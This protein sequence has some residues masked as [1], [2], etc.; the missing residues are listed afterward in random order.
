VGEGAGAGWQAARQA[1]IKKAV[2]RRR[3]W[4]F[5]RFAPWISAPHRWIGAQ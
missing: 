3:N 4:I 2:I 1:V 5:I